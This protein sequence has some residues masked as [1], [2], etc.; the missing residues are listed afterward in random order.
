MAKRKA[1]RPRTERSAEERAHTRYVL[2]VMAVTAIL[3]S[4]VFYLAWKGLSKPRQEEK[5][6]PHRTAPHGGVVTPVGKGDQHDHAEAVVEKGGVLTVYTY[7]DDAGTALEVELQFPTALVRPDGEVEAVPVVL[8]PFP[9]RG[10]GPGKTSR[11]TCKLSR[12][13][14]GRSLVITVADLAVDQTRFRLEFAATGGG[15]GNEAPAADTEEEERRLFLTARGKYTEADIKA[16]GAETTSKKFKMFQLA[17]DPK[18]R[19][20]DRIC[21][22][23]RTKAS[24]ACSW[25]VDGQAYLFCCP[26]CVEEFVRA[27]KERPDEVRHVADYIQK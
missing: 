15:Q 26:P 23:T 8:L 17:H 24:A 13:S 16:N 1:S 27:S 11:F 5:V 21:P 2:L 6:H 19:P 10:D 22:V 14:R 7:S 20:G 12:E 25:T 3:T 4:T 18:P 9:Q